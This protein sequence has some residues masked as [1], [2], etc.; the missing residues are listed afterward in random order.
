[1][2]ASHVQ[3]TVVTGVKKDLG[4]LVVVAAAHLALLT[5]R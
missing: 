3:G 5:A 1:M 2:G 4:E